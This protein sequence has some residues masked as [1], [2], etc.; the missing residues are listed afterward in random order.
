MIAAEVAFEGG[1]DSTIDLRTSCI[2]AKLKKIRKKKY[3]LN[4]GLHLC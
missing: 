2:D 1:K 3:T 4:K